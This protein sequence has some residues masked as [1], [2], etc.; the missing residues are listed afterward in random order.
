MQKRHAKHVVDV[1]NGFGEWGGYMDAKKSKLEEQFAEDVLKNPYK[2]SELFSGISI[3]VNGL[4]NPSAEELKQIMMIHGGVYH[5]YQRSSTTFIIAS[6][7]PDTKIRQITTAKIISPQWICECIRMNKIIDY[8]NYLLYT[9]SKISQPKITFEKKSVQLPLTNDINANDKVHSQ[10]TKPDMNMIDLNLDILN[11]AIRREEQSKCNDTALLQTNESSTKNEVKMGHSKLAKTAVDPN[12]LTE[13]YNNSRLHHISTLGASLKQFISQLRENHTG[14]FPDLN[15]LKGI[16]QMNQEHLTGNN[17]IMHIDMDCFFVSVGL[18]SRPNLKGFPIAVTHSKGYNG[19]N[20]KNEIGVDRKKEMEL[21]VKRHEDK[22]MTKQLEID[23]SNDKIKK[24]SSIDTISLSEIASCSYEARKTGVRN[25]MFVGAALKLCPQLKT[26]PYDFDAYK[27]IAHMLYDTITKYTMD[28]E[29]VSCD[30][31]YVNL[32]NVINTLKCSVEDFVSYIRTQISERTQCPC[33]AGIGENK[34]QAR[35][36]TKKAKPNGQFHLKNEKVEEFFCDIPISDLPGVGQSTWQR[37]SNLGLTT[38]A[39]L[40]RI[41]LAKLQQEFG[42]K[43]GETLY[44]YCRGLDNKP[45]IYDQV[46][47]SVSAEIN[48][49]I[50]FT[51]EKELDTFLNQLVSEVH[52]RLTEISAKAK[53][54]TL[55]YMVRAKEAPIETAK[56]LGHGFC[57][58]LTKSLT[59]STY[60]SDL[61]I[62][63][64]KV[65]N[66]KKMLNVSPKEVRGIG[67]QISKLNHSKCDMNRKNSLKSLFARAQ[68]SHTE[69]IA[70][71]NVEQNTSK[72][73]TK[74]TDHKLNLRKV[75]SFN[76]CDQFDKTNSNNSAR[77]LH[78][79][80]DEL[81]LTVLSEL[82]KEIQEEI[83]LDGD[84]I[85]TYDSNV[86][87]WLRPKITKNTI[88]RKLE[89]DFKDINGDHKHQKYI[90]K[91]NILRSNEWRQILSYWLQSRVDPNDSDIKSIVYFFKEFA[92]AH[93]LCDVS[94]ALKFLHRKIEKLNCRWHQIYNIIVGEVQNEVKTV[95][96][97]NVS[98]HTKNFSNC[99][100]CIRK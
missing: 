11:T 7:L 67:I 42:K 59:L 55:K 3:F 81:D 21:Y 95:F 27:E 35:M 54:I 44:Q 5:T 74:K 75:K 17:I 86:K 100:N 71:S 40:Q 80:C 58:N 49:G 96:P 39:D 72:A 97:A 62:I 43:H 91:E 79:I 38:C 6:H 88:A 47:K 57:D 98:L 20:L 53:M 4:T 1:H 82:P 12:F 34:L 52:T 68:N 45:L 93:K 37:C 50:R 33:S 24:K 23:N 8:S 13:F 87:N 85:S 28:V 65:F 63:S 89:N 15:K 16:L 83:L 66:I 14:E 60:T 99:K 46:R 9:N 64:Q 25:G 22:Y 90:S 31:M 32:T 78:K 61:Q 56:F 48:Y 51:T 84:A 2:K 29:A 36:A 76:G 77:K 73:C 10:Q 30:E 26:I 18:R 94:I 41:S 69:I 70:Q 92:C 19:N